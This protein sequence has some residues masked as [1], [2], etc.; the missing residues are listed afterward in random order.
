MNVP[1]TEGP[2]SLLEDEGRVGLTRHR[3]GHPAGCTIPS[4][5]QDTGRSVQGQQPPHL[6]PGGTEART[7]TGK[8]PHKLTCTGLPALGSQLSSALA[9][10][11]APQR[12]DPGLLWV[13]GAGGKVGP[14]C[15]LT[16]PAQLLRDGQA[17]ASVRDGLQ[18]GR[19]SGPPGTRCLGPHSVQPRPPGRGRMALPRGSWDSWGR[20][21][22]PP[23]GPKGQ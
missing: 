5:T 14:A 10:C 21:P 1:G 9:V 3:P 11:P 13:L 16:S 19:E 22:H 20:Q 7:A 18:V 6:H 8:G 15:F 12:W 23:K 17:E 2:T 4:V